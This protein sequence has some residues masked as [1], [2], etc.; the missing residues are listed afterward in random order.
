MSSSSPYEFVFPQHLVK[1]V[2]PR[3]GGVEVPQPPFAKDA[4]K[5]WR[6]RLDALRDEVNELL[7]SDQTDADIA[8]AASDEASPAWA[9][10]ALHV[11][12]WDGLFRLGGSLWGEA[13][14]SWADAAVAA[15]GPVAAA[16]V[17]VW[18]AATG[19]VVEKQDGGVVYTSRA[20]YPGWV[21]QRR[22]GLGN[23]SERLAGFA[24]HRLGHH[25]QILSPHDVRLR[26][27][28]A[29]SGWDGVVEALEPLAELG[30]LARV[31][32]AALVPQRRDWYA[33]A[34]RGRSTDLLVSAATTGEL[35]AFAGLGQEKWG[36][37][38]PH[39]A[40]PTLLDALGVEVAELAKAAF[41]SGALDKST[42]PVDVLTE[43]PTQTAF[44]LLLKAA[45]TSREAA[46][47]VAAQTLRWPRIAA[48]ILAASAD[49]NPR[50]RTLLGMLSVDDLAEHRDEFAA[51]QW[52]TI[53]AHAKASAGSVAEVG[54]VPELLVSPPW[55]DRP[56]VPMIKLAPPEGT[57]VRWLPGEREQ[58]S[59]PSA[60]RSYRDGGR[61]APD[62]LRG[63]VKAASSLVGGDPAQVLPF[64]S[65]LG[66]ANHLAQF[67]V[68]APP[69]AT[70]VVLRPV[71]RAADLCFRKD[72]PL[73]RMVLARQED[74]AL[75]AKVA[76]EY[77]TD[78]YDW[79]DP[80]HA[81]RNV[82][83]VCREWAPTW[84]QWSLV[85]PWVN[86]ATVAKMAEWLAGKIK[87]RKEVARQYLLRNAEA[88]SAYLFPAAF[89]KPGKAQSAAMM[90]LGFLQTEG[91]AEQ[92]A[93]AAAT[94]GSQVVETWSAVAAT[95]GLPQPMP[96]V[97]GWS[98]VGGL[99]QVQLASG[100]GALPARAVENLVVMAAISTID[101]PYA[102]LQVVRE[103]CTPESLAVFAW[104]LFEQWQVAGHPASEGW[105]LDALGSFGNDEAARRLAPLVRAWP[106][107]SAHARAVKGL[108]VL[109]G[110]GTDVAL[111]QLHSIS[112]KVKFKGIKDQAQARIDDLAERL[113]LTSAQLSDR[114][115]PDLGLGS[116]GSMVL[117]FGDK[118]F[119]VGFDELLRPTI[120]DGDGK[121]R[122]A[123]PKT[124]T[125]PGASAAKTF[126][127]LKK[128]VRAIA[129]LQLR[130]L[131]EAMVTQR[132]WTVEEFT[133]YL[134]DHPLVWH[135]TR[136]LV[137][138][139][140]NGFFRVAEDRSFADV[141]DET[142]TPVGTVRLAHQLNLGGHAPMWAALLADYE[143]GQPFPQVGRDTYTVDQVTGFDNLVV[144][145]GKVLGLEKRGWRRGPA[146]DGGGQWSIDRPLPDGKV[147]E[148]GLEPGFVVGEP[149]MFDEQTLHPADLT[150]LDPI[151]CS[152][153]LRDLHTLQG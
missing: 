75:A 30:D 34:D 70:E 32:M 14:R 76:L 144:G 135:L 39:P 153:I 26:L 149:M 128:D 119:T 121:P 108:D 81:G 67:L 36:W 130:R 113:G 33:A 49:T 20:L 68:E 79:S 115:V 74:Q 56:P 151:T 37:Y 63:Y 61:A 141:D 152:E 84:P 92:V 54:E 69:S 12:D 10:M 114:L 4:A 132:C 110:I 146:M 107:E 103:A 41:E 8:A 93:Q 140:D 88:A 134:V 35:M 122:K 111:M 124:A 15:L 89:G 3:P 55:M 100:A 138:Q 71:G 7:A 102:G 73:L 147:W 101:A 38:D 62:V 133:T 21:R 78:G 64:V 97:P 25:E 96:T 104:G 105:V 123:L 72:L 52:A 139:A 44:Q 45:D 99:P 59:D 83:G 145:S 148:L 48:P 137:W 127:T 86:R 43:I 47:A 50:S 129:D 98:A 82:V 118:T 126:A 40:W 51:A 120:A 19:V 117:D 16:Q 94:Y 53:E 23:P 28:L 13:P 91:R 11:S 1:D 18:W 112:Q 57:Q 131:E 143:I 5:R 6:T 77:A 150:G 46:T 9:A 106:G 27:R 65:R 125:E 85:Y 80:H 31:V 116:D 17:A 136:R 29:A 109:L 95:A 42:L 66:Q 58:W 142:F 60:V 87:D 22:D 2:L 90:A 24:R